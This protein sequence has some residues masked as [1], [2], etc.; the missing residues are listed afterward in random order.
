MIGESRLF[1]L[2]K[3]IAGLVSAASPIMDRMSAGTDC[4]AD[5]QE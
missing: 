5:F 4:R 2:G 1:G 3:L